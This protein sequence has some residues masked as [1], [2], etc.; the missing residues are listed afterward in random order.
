M[1]KNLQT[2][3]TFATLDKPLDLASFFATKKVKPSKVMVVVIP[4][5][6]N[7]NDR[8]IATSKNRVARHK[9]LQE[10]Q[11]GDFFTIDQLK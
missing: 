7:D 1:V 5:Y 8:T 6:D 3:T 4:Q 11:E 9:A 10:Y 2:I